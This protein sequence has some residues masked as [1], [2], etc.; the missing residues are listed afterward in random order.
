MQNSIIKEQIRK[1]VARSG[2]G[3]AVWVPKEWLG[4][5][6]IVTR[7]ETPKLSLEEELINILLPYLKDICGIFLYG[8]Y[9]RKEETKNSDM[10]ILVIGKNKIKIENTKRFDINFIEIKK[11]KEAVQKNPFIYAIINEA[12]PI[13]N[14][15]LLDELKQNKK[16]FKDFIRWFKETTYDSIKI[17]N[18]FIDL[19][20]IE[21]NYLVSYNVIYS[22]IL[23]LKGIFLI[24]SV[25]EN[26][27]FSNISF[28]RFI[29][30]FIS[31]SELR[32]LYEAYRSIRDDK[33]LGNLKIEI[34]LIKKLFEVLQRE[35]KNLDGK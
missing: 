13:I 29:T 9:A 17:T 32:K 30:Q 22:L 18:E 10:D 15:Y 27:E 19:D 28:K 35:V 26:K 20:K 12:K 4:E 21:S 5:E 33:K 6:I 2:N 7:I 16:D 23:R 24:K 25:L 8:S 11:I 1:K 34:S 31:E 3:G 14:S